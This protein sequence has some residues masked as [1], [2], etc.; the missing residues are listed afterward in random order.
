MAKADPVQ[1]VE[2][3]SE[4]CGF[5]AAPLRR[6]ESCLCAE[7]DVPMR[8]GEFFEGYGLCQ[9]TEFGIG[10]ITQAPQ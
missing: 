1:L 8:E 5:R 2:R 9:A 4:A 10:A 7:E 6:G 3:G